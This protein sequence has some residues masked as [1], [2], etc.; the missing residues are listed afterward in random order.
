MAVPHTPAE[1]SDPRPG[2]GIAV[3]GCTGA[4]DWLARLAGGRKRARASPIEKRAFFTNRSLG[5]L[6]IAPQLLLIFTFFYW[7]AGEAL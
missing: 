7:P 2:S 6:L 1:T 4:T 3:P 5:L